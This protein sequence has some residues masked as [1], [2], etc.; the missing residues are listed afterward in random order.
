M[1]NP[2]LVDIKGKKHLVFTS[3]DIPEKS[4]E[5]VEKEDISKDDNPILDCWYPSIFFY[6][7]EDQKIVEQIDGGEIFVELKNGLVCYVANDYY[8]EFENRKQFDAEIAKYGADSPIKY[9]NYMF[10]GTIF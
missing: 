5:Q 1:P 7:F 4:W 8:I 10:R 9:G 2:D 3:Y 6:C